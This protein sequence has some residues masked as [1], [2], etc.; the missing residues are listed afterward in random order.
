MLS[1]FEGPRTNGAL[2]PFAFSHHQI[3]RYDQ[4]NRTMTFWT[5]IALATFLLTRN[6]RQKRDTETLA[7]ND[8]IWAAEAAARVVSDRE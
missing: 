7:P 8:S 5:A 3:I 6:G 4:P 2:W 1:E